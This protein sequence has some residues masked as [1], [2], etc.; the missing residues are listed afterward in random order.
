MRIVPLGE[1][2]T[3]RAFAATVF[4]WGTAFRRVN[5]RWSNQP[6]RASRRGATVH[7][8]YQLR[9]NAYRVLLTRGRDACVVFVPPIALLDET[10]RYLADAGFRELRDELLQGV[11]RQRP[12][13]PVA[14]QQHASGRAKA[15]AM[16]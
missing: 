4:A 5:G 11:N 14:A 1:S 2:A 12:A 10:Y 7:D 15:T 13:P 3:G 6:A 9:V 16:R 8:P